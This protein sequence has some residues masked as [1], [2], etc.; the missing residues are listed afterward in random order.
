ME[1]YKN[2]WLDTLRC[3]WRCTSKS[4]TH[5]HTHTLIHTHCFSFSPLFITFLYLT[6]KVP[7]IGMFPN[8]NSFTQGERAETPIPFW[9]CCAFWLVLFG[10]QHTVYSGRQAI[11]K[12]IWF[13]YVAAACRTHRTGDILS[14]LQP[15]SIFLPL[16][17]PT[18]KPECCFWIWKSVGK[19]GPQKK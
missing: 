4:R 13:D 18:A 19:C 8:Q 12:M 14:I 7:E 10:P 17:F 16:R 5:S 6:F 3:A 15:G 11:R 1:P 9:S 2:I